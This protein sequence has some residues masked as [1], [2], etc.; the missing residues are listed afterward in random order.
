MCAGTGQREDAWIQYARGVAKSVAEDGS[1]CLIV[2]SVGAGTKFLPQAVVHGDSTGSAVRDMHA[3]ILA[4]RGFVRFLYDQLDRRKRGEPCLL[5]VEPAGMPREGMEERCQLR[6]RVILYTSSMPCGN[7]CLKRWSKGRIEEFREELGNWEMPPE[8]HP[9]F[10]TF[11]R[12]EGQVDLLLKGSLDAN[13]SASME[14]NGIP[15]G[16]EPMARSEA[17]EP[18]TTSSTSM[19]QPPPAKRSCHR[20]GTIPPGTCSVR[21]I[22]SGVQQRM[23]LAVGSLGRGEVV[24]R[25]TATCS[26]KICSWSLCGVQGAL[27]ARF[28][29][30][31]YCSGVVI[32]RKYGFEPA[33]R[34]LCCRLAAKKCFSRTALQRLSESSGY[35]LHHPAI[36]CTGVKLD[37]GAIET[38]GQSSGAKFGS[39]EDSECMVWTLGD[40]AATTIGVCVC[41]CTSGPLRCTCHATGFYG[42]TMWH[43]DIVA[44]VCVLCATDPCTGL[45]LEGDVASI[46]RQSMYRRYLRLA[47]IDPSTSYADAKSQ[48]STDF[49]RAKGTLIDP[50]R[51]FQFWPREDPALSAWS[52]APPPPPPEP[53]SGVDAEA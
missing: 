38:L 15:V 9:P 20:T 29:A 35:S 22:R 5:L 43:W 13:L 17:G 45:T 44:C 51:E 50:M 37:E 26:D 23:D 25:G 53:V 8:P 2:V 12:D 48:A 39:S 11:A 7:A 21:E 47:G 30:P 28:I 19:P 34:A 36:M 31:V 46:A 14:A 10:H 3:E 40:V 27:V 1:T 4:R 49:Q 16:S 33:R 6:G 52:L 41:A 24:V 32:G 18:S 42:N